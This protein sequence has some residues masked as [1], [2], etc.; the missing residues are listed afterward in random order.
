MI[1]KGERLFSF[2]FFSP[3]FFF[4]FALCSFCFLSRL[5]ILANKIQNLFF[6]NFKLAINKNPSFLAMNA[7]FSNSSFFMSF[8]QILLFFSFFFQLNIFFLKKIFFLVCYDAMI[9]LSG[10]RT[11]A[12]YHRRAVERTSFAWERKGFEIALGRT[13]AGFALR[14]I[15]WEMFNRIHWRRGAVSNLPGV[16]WK[17]R[18]A[19]KAGS[20][21][22]GKD[23]KDRFWFFLY[24]LIL[25]F[26][27]MDWLIVLTSCGT[28]LL[29]RFPKQNARPY[30]IIN[31]RKTKQIV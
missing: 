8:F 15:S 29:I 14:H 11:R 20:K 17:K 10:H 9:L 3:F 27:V 30:Y 7:F 31:K 5:T 21:V 16:T 12:S 25:S 6:F 13:R 19:V 2:R 4:W 23:T 22:G 18:E 28:L 24:R 1:K 26:D